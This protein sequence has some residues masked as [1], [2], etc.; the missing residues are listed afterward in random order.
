M[1]TQARLK[2]R[3]IYNPITGIFTNKVTRSSRA[4]IGLEAGSLHHKGYLDIKID[5]S[6]YRC[7]RLAFLYMNGSFPVDGVDHINHIK[8]DNR[9]ENLREATQSENCR[10]TPLRKNSKSG[11][12]GV[13]WDY[14]M[15]CWVVGIHTNGRQIYLGCFVDLEKAKEARQAANIKYGFHPNHGK[16]ASI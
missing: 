5:N 2:E 9:W 13:T 14:R 11:C 8:I 10:N 6:I 16:E 4:V 1:L 7:H 3:L 12:S 15:E